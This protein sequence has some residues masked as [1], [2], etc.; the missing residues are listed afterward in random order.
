MWNWYQPWLLWTW[1]WNLPDYIANVDKSKVKK[2][3]ESMW[4]EDFN[5]KDANW[6]V[7]D[8]WYLILT[9]NWEENWKPQEKIRA[10]PLKDVSDWD[11]YYDENWRQIKFR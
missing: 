1:D 7:T 9:N 4:S 5:L 6:W 2:A 11:F 3:V 10:I 8:K